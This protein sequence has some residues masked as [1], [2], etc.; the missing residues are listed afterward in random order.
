MGWSGGHSSHARR[1]RLAGTKNFCMHSISS[2]VPSRKARGQVTQKCR[3]TAQVEIGVTRHAKL[4]DR[5]HVKVAGSIEV[6]A[7]LVLRARPAVPYVAPAV[8]Q[9]L[10]Q[11]PRLLKERVILAI[12]R[13]IQPPDFA[14]GRL[15]SQSVQHR[16]NRCRSNAR[17][18]QDHGAITG[19][20][21]KA[22]ARSADVQNITRP[23]LSV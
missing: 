3:W 21:G 16:Q 13:P 7:Q 20:Q 10:E 5:G 6:G 8:R 12:A 14:R 9:P 15:G 19:A 4:L 23:D 17:A 2:D 22:A 1:Y 18:K 11:A